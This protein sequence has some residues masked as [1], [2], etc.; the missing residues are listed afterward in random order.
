MELFVFARF[1]AAEGKEEELA[2][3]LRD[4]VPLVRGEP[5][6]LM[7]EACGSVRDARLFFIHSRWKDEAAFDVH[8]EIPNT[9]GFIARAEA[10]IDHPFDVSR[11][12]RI[13]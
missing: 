3:L 8:A 2:R 12:A 1:H 10:L 4:Q 13:A 6:C 11:T 7:I 9:T 5:G